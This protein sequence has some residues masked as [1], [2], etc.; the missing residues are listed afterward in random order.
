[1]IVVDRLASFGR[2]A[3]SYALDIYRNRWLIAELTRREFKARHLGSALGFIWAFTHP[4]IMMLI[5]WYVFTY[6]LSGVGPVNNAPFLIWILAGLVPWFLASDSIAG[7]ASAVTDNR[8]L[9]KKVVFRVSLLPIIRL[10]SNLPVH[11]FLVIVI[12]A[13][14]WARGYPPTWF[15]FQ[16]LYYLAALLALGLGWTLLMSAMVPFLKDIGQIVQVILQMAF[17]ITPLIWH[18]EGASDH[19]KTLAYLN[20]LCYIVQGYRESLVYHVGFWR[21]WQV[22]AYYWSVTLLMLIV[23]ALV[24]S[25]LRAHFADVL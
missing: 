23:G 19:D 18:V 24:F 6:R 12:I 22:G 2:G 3:V 4:G 7:G 20:P 1:V 25:R 16:V 9:V 21:H 11:L 14:F 8:F 5:Y 15:T 13:I 10:L 17:W